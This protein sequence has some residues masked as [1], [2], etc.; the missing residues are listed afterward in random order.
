MYRD[1]SSESKSRGGCKSRFLRTAWHRVQ[2][3]SPFT[4]LL[5]LCLFLRVCFHMQIFLDGHDIR[6]LELHWLRS[7]IGLVGQEPLLFSCSIRENICYGCPDASEEQVLSAAADSNALTFIRQLPE[8]LETQVGVPAILIHVPTLQ[9]II[10]M[11]STNHAQSASQK[12]CW[13]L[14]L[15]LLHGRGRMSQSGE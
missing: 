9:S 14:S 2:A 8:G 11:Y 5:V 7:Q 10:D 15:L 6:D 4:Q 12:A 1:M 3:S 13:R